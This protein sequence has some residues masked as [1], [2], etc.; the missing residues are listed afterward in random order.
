MQPLLQFAL[1]TAVFV[2]AEAVFALYPRGQREF[3]QNLLI[4]LFNTCVTSFAIAGLAYA[5]FRGL[6]HGVPTAVVSAFAA[7]PVALQVVEATVVIDFGIYVSHRL[8]HTPLLWRFH[9]IHH[10]AEEM[11]WL[12][13]FRNHPVDLTVYTIFASVPVALLGFAPAA[14]VIAKLIHSWQTVISHA[15]TRLDIGPLRHV[16]V[17]PAFHHWHHANDKAAYDRNFGALFVFWDVIF[18]T[19]NRTVEPHPAAFGT[20]GPRDRDIGDLI[21]GPFRPKSPPPHNAPA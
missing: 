21:A 6:S 15:N 8:S 12:V 3:R 9:E 4:W 11:N 2:P 17:G 14:L 7:Q 10:S 16:F 1:W 19:V 20:E 13:S 18:G 5:L